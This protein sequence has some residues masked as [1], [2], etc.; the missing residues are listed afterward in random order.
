MTIAS[1]L[2]ISESPLTVL[3]SLA[4]LIGLNEAIALQ[5]VKYWLTNV[6]RDPGKRST[7]FKNGKWWVY[8]TYEG[9]KDGNFPFWSIP[10][11]RRTFN[12]LEKKNLLTSEQFDKKNGN[13]KKWY[14]INTE[15]LSQLVT[16]SDQNDQTP[17]DRPFTPS[18]QNDQT[19][20]SNRSDPVINVISSYIDSETTSEITTE[21]KT[22]LTPRGGRVVSRFPEKKQNISSCF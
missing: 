18:D 10:T 8:N 3:P 12:S 4:V 21:N 6:S 14:S 19:L 13:C 5:Q 16:P 2:L 1:C 15:V 22:P 17:C 7:H 20:R 9:W 11:I